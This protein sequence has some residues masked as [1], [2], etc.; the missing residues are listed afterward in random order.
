MESGPSSSS[1]RNLRVAICSC[2][3][4]MRFCR[5]LVSKG[6]SLS[7]GS[8]WK[9]SVCRACWLPLSDSRSFWAMPVKRERDAKGDPIVT[10]V[11]FCLVG[12]RFSPLLPWG[13]LCRDSGSPASGWLPPVPGSVMPEPEYGRWSGFCGFSAAGFPEQKMNWQSWSVIGFRPGKRLRNSVWE[14]YSWWP[15][16]SQVAISSA[17]QLSASG[18]GFS[19]E[20]DCFLRKSLFLG[21]PLSD[22][23][24]RKRGFRRRLRMKPAWRF[25]LWFW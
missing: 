10:E 11:W 14:K 3:L 1:G 2:A 15:E 6:L 12:V 5:K 7:S 21:L 9:R 16:I 19:W 18:F 17:V 8:V 24:R 22:T 4:L 23:N 13:W 25:R 20:P